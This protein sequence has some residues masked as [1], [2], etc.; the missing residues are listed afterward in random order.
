M[1]KKQDSKIGHLTPQET[2]KKTASKKEI[3]EIFNKAV[4][5]YGKTLE[6]LSKN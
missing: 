5:T 1:E 6:R 4:K 3:Q 2:I